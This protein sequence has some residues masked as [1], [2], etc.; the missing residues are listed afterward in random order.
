M[1]FCSFSKENSSSG[2]T[3]IDNQFINNYLSDAPEN[4]VRVYLYGLFA[5]QNELSSDNV[6]SF[7]EFLNLEESEVIDCFKYWDDFGVLSIISNEPFTVKY[8]P[9][10]E[11]T[12]KYRKF[13]PEKYEDFSKS[14]QSVITD[15]MIS[16]NE[17]NE[18][19][20]LM[21]STSLK[22]QAFLMIIQ[23]CAN[24]KGA[25]VG[26]K[27][28]IAVA[29]DFIAR[30]I[31]TPDLIESEIDGYIFAS[32]EITSVFKALKSTKMPEIEDMQAYKYWTEKLGFEH[33]FILQVIKHSKVKN[34]KKLSN[35]IEELYSNKC[36]TE[37][38]AKAYFIHKNEL[39]NLA[40]EVTKKLGIY[41]EVLDNVLS[42]Y[43]SPWLSKGFDKDT[44]LFIADYCFKKNKRTLELMDETVS[45]LYKL[46][47]ITIQSITLY[48]ENFNKND[49]FIEKM[50]D[51]AGVN[52]KPNN[53]DREN[54]E[55]WRS[56]NF[57]DEMIIEAAKRSSHTS[58]P[59]TYMNSILSNWKSQNIFELDKIPT[60]KQKGAQTQHFEN[61][62]KYS[63]NEL[64]SL[65][66][67]FDDFK[68]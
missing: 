56:W 37:S 16:V 3:F 28:I 13:N 8:Y 44:I 41:I 50:L 11:S 65:F 10:N 5:C 40:I 62:R 31:I 24:L 36:F 6:K 58:N 19:F 2:K 63:Q 46:G 35:L 39:Y 60:N 14:I 59:I 42:S 4:A 9:V 34:I 1:S 18:Y 26:Y 57:T 47:L 54:L 38:D 49:K 25:N 51:F 29:K 55:N 20:Q 7:A 48:I 23:Y 53:W 66:S 15:R 61:E 45:K 32:N 22:P 12:S 27:Y 67:S 68:V 64:D 43:L 52:R 17:Y 33:E 30:G 21:E